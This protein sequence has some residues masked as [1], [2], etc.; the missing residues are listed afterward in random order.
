MRYF[1]L[2]LLV[3]VLLGLPGSPARAQRA[4]VARDGVAVYALPLEDEQPVM[5]LSRGDT[6]NVLG[7]RGDWVKITRAD[8]R[9]GWMRLQAQ[10]NGKKRAKQAPQHP[11]RSESEPPMLASN[12]SRAKGVE[13]PDR[14]VPTRNTK[15]QSDPAVYRR[16]GYAFGMGLVELDYTYNWKFVFHSRPR[17]ALEGSFKH[18][19]GDAANSYFLMANFSYLLKESGRTLPYATAGLGVITTVPERSVDLGSV[20]HMALNYGFGLRRHLRNKLSLLLAAT[21]YATFVGRSV[22][23]FNEITVGVLVGRFWD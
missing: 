6:V 9:R 23:F 21:Q 12:G 19:L 20:S 7:R 1:A 2:S 11:K 16:F 10:G 8:G 4:L 3:S 18:V 22:T 5:V 15:N 13:T 14:V 17:L